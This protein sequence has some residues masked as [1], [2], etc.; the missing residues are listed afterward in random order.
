[1][2]TLGVSY[3]VRILN[4]LNNKISRLNYAF[5]IPIRKIQI[6]DIWGVLKFSRTKNGGKSSKIL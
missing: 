1:M 4:L 6:E 5:T 2:T 3:F